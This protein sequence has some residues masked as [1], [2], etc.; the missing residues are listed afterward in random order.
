MARVLVLSPHPDDEAI[1][2]GGTICSHRDAGDAVRVVYLTSGEQGG[3]GMSPA[4]TRER[5]E[6]EAAVAAR[7]LDVESIDFWRAPD[8]ALRADATLGSRLSRLLLEW[9]P[10]VVYTTHDGETHPDHRAASRIVRR[11][12]SESRCAPEVFLFEIWTPLIRMDRIVDITPWIDRKIDAVRAYESQ[13]AVLRF[14]EA[15][16]GL[17]RY[18]GEMHSWPDGDYA[19]VFVALRR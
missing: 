4:A 10:D 8:G 6:A 14:D 5:R 11:A 16:R 12:L 18:R 15:I 17:N 2:C 1:G 19:E 9:R 3:H 7:V 13:C